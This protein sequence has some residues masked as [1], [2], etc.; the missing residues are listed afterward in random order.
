MEPTSVEGLLVE[1]EPMAVMLGDSTAVVD[2][3]M[4]VAVMLE[5]S[6][7]VADMNMA[8]ADIAVP[9]VMG[10]LLDMDGAVVVAMPVADMGEGLLVAVEP[11]D[12]AVPMDVV[13]KLD[14][15]VPVAVVDMPM[16]V[17]PVDI[18]NLVDGGGVGL[19]SSM[20]ILGVLHY[21]ARG[22]SDISVVGGAGGTASFDAG[23]VP[24]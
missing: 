17:V 2:M 21:H 18:D 4:A 1:V 3:N 23:L 22:V 6:T 5:D 11:G 12:I 9:V 24:S 20:L 13:G 7:A 10:K 15:V 19:P 8:E 16:V 14:I